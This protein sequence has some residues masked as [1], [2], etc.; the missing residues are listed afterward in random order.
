LPLYP[1]TKHASFAAADALRGELAHKNIE[2]TIL[3][4]GLLSTNIWNGAR[5]RPERFGGPRETDPAI[6]TLWREAKDPAL[7]WPHIEQIVLGGGGYLTCS[8]DGSEKPAIEERAT[9]LQSSIIEI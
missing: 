6:S 8:T 5:A 1:V 3:F 4:P 2:S 9:L 7:M